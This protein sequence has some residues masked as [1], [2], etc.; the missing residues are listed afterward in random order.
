MTRQ[1]KARAKALCVALTEAFV[2]RFEFEAVKTM[3]GDFVIHRY[4]PR[5][6]TTHRCFIGK[7]TGHLYFY[8]NRSVTLGDSAWFDEAEEHWKKLISQEKLAVFSA[9]SAARG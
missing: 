5:E 3:L 7:G 6:T 2:G 4:T 8:N 9:E 1:E